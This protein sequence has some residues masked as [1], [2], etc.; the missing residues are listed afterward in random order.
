MITYKMIQEAELESV[1]ASVRIGEEFSVLKIGSIG[2]WAV[3]SMRGPSMRSWGGSYSWPSENYIAINGCKRTSH[4]AFTIFP[5][6]QE[7]QDHYR[8]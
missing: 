4:E 2:D 5:C 3:Y 6:D 1:L 8:R 7:A